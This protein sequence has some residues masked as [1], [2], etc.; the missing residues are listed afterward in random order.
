MKRAGLVLAFLVVSFLPALGAFAVRTGGWYAA[1]NKPLWNPPP[2]VF[3][4]VWSVL[5]LMIGLAGYFAWTRGDRAERRVDFAVYGA[6][7][8]MNA[9]WTPLFFGLRRPMLALADLIVLWFLIVLCIGLFALRSRL[10][11]WLMF[12]YFLWVSFAGALNAVILA[13]NAG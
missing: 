12:P 8:F 2:W 11:A 6:Q 5:Y 3:G 1:L 10:A 4:P 13:M 7:L 9:L